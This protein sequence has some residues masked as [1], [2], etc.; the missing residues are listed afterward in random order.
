MC[1][2]R[3]GSCDKLALETKQDNWPEGKQ[4]PGSTLINVLTS[5]SHNS[6]SSLSAF[7][8]TSFCMYSTCVINTL[9][10][11]IP[12]V[13]VRI[14]FS[15]WT[16]ASIL[17]CSLLYVPTLTSV[18][19]YRKMHSLDYMDLCRQSNVPLFKMLSRFVKA[20]LPR[21]KCLLFSWLQSP[22]AVIWEPEKI[23]S[24]TISTLLHLFAMK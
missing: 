8:Y 14:F 7:V 23:K 22:S 11:S 9:L 1:T 19:D 5:K 13:P 12:S 6:Y 2:H 24:V 20:F 16:V 4:R 21:N 3:E 18:H 10:S 17:W 15:K